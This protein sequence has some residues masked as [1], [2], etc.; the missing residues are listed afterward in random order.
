MLDELS[1]RWDDKEQMLKDEIEAAFVNLE[2][3]WQEE[4]HELDMKCASPFSAATHLG[5][6]HRH[7]C[8][9]SETNI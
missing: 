7:A 4:A 6:W 9:Q 3:K 8:V 5:P 1:R 2:T